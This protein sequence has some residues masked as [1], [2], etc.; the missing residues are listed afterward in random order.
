[1][2]GHEHGHAGHGHAAAA[3]GNRRR[4]A[5]A[6]WLT[7]TVLIVE[8]VG[9]VTTRSLVLAVDAMHMLTDV[10][11]LGLA[12][13]AGHLATRPATPTYT[14]GFERAEIISALAQSAILLGV[15]VFAIVEGIQRL[16]TP[17]EVPAAGLLV[18]G[19]VGLVANLLSLWVLAGGTGSNL[20]IRAAVLEV[21]ND[22]A[23]SLAVL[24]SG[25]LLA[26]LGWD[27]VDTVAALLVA[28]LILPR[29]VAVLSRA[30]R[31]L[32]EAAPEGIEAEA[33]RA[34]LERVPGILAVH[35]L[36]VS[37]LSSSTT[38]LTAHV[39]V[40]ERAFIDGT[41]PELLARLQTCA[42]EHFEVPLGHAT[43]QLEPPHGRDAEGPLHSS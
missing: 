37:R 19:A 11:G 2:S 31:V 13:T 29:A 16:F 17:A 32:M 22:A 1:M 21:A 41:A 33:L 36:H 6:F 18:F 35:D 9:A 4:L 23:G 26:T 3:R 39:V 30:I 25:I 40:H 20:S 7:A 10:L 43:F 42:A 15:G 34:H 8:L 5:I 27:R 38:V 12:L 28:A 14:W 24:V